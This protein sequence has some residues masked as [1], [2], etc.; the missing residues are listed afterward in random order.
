M[1]KDQNLRHANKSHVFE[2]GILMDFSQ[3]LQIN[4]KLELLRERSPAGSR[5]KLEFQARGENIIGTLQTFGL[6]K[7]FKVSAM[8]N[9]PLL[10]YEK[11]EKQIDLKLLN[12]KRSRFQEKRY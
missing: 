5:T 2:Y 8:G 3:F 4:R 7:K 9:D 10:I 1:F 12:W 11:L 6:S